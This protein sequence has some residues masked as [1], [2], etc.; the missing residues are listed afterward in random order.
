MHA[1][2]AKAKALLLIS[3]GIDS[4]VA[5]KIAQ[6]HGFELEAIHFSQQPFTDDTPEKKSLALCKKLSIPE[7]IVVEAGEE[8]KEIA[9]KT[10]RE[11]YFVL[12]KRFMMKVSEKIAEQHGCRFLVTGESMGQVSSQTAS[13]LNSINSATK[14]EILRPLLFMNKQ[15]ITD[16]SVK[17]GFFD[18]SKGPEMCD[19]LASGSPKTITTIEDVLREEEKCGME[20]L[21]ERAAKKTRIEKTKDAKEVVSA[22]EARVCK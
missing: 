12:M 10:F 22:D 18:T 11:Y 6:R 1:A 20:A 3:G 21:A 9:D 17:E 2:S 7:M 19:A 4:P 5:G 14:I 13:N 15:E 8:L 16:V